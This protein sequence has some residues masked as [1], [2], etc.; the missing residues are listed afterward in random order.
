MGG[1]FELISSLLTVLL[2]G[3][4]G[5]SSKI[6]KILQLNNNV[7]ESRLTSFR[8]VLFC[9]RNQLKSKLVYL[10]RNMLMMKRIRTTDRYHGLGN[11]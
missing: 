7:T 5:R 1:I 10:T 3:D 4:R 11:L 2:D 9:S 8:E 6:E